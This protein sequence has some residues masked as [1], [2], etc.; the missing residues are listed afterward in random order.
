MLN[1]TGGTIPVPQDGSLPVISGAIAAISRVITSQLPM[2]KATLPENKT[3][4]AS[5]WKTSFL[6]GV[7]L[8]PGAFVSAVHVKK[9]SDLL[10]R[11]ISL[12][13]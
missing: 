5:R 7:G 9:V 3:N 12:Q 10:W 6:L 13:K 8:F 2:Y 1:L 11:P 4:I